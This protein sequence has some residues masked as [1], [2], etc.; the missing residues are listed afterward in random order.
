MAIS[1]TLAALL[2]MVAATS[3]ARDRGPATQHS[4]IV[5]MNP[6]ANAAQ[7]YQAEGVAN[8]IL[9][10]AEVKM[11]WQGDVRVCDAPR[12]GIVIELK[13]DTPPDFHPGAMAYALPYADT[14]YAGTTIVLFYDR[15]QAV[16][17]PRLLAHVLA[18][19]ITHVLES[20]GDHSGTGIMKARWTPRDYEDMSRRP[21]KLAEEDLLLI[22][23]GLDF[24]EGRK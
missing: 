8:Q 16:R 20:T 6:G 23:K 5:C 21:L 15:I 12:Y 3:F 24:R 7:V 11:H 4:V 14:T 18:H 19:E 22:R 9:A 17:V 1:R 13:L 2:T 10:P